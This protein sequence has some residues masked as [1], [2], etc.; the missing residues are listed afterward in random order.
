MDPNTDRRTPPSDARLTIRLVASLKFSLSLF[1]LCYMT[2]FHKPRTMCPHRHLVRPQRSATSAA[3][4]AVL[5]WHTV[6]LG[7]RLR[8]GQSYT[9]RA[10]CVDRAL[11][12]LD[13]RPVPPFEESCCTSF[14]QPG[15]PL[16][17]APQFLSPIPLQILHLSSALHVWHWTPYRAY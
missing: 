4:R 13:A 6:C 14:D 1:S 5:A 12:G 7:T 10:V 11:K 8:D 2:W 3:I 15:H 17:G 16:S 9:H